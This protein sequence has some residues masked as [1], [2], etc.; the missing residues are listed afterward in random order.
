MKYDSKQTAAAA[1]AKNNL[2]LLST[3]I[4]VMLIM[5]FFAKMMHDMVFYAGEMTQYVQS[6]SRDMHDMRNEFKTMTDEVARIDKRVENMNNKMNNMDVQVGEIQAAISKD[7]K[8]LN[9]LVD[10][11]A[12]DVSSMTSN[13]DQIQYIMLGMHRALNYGTRT[14]THPVRMFKNFTP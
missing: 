10:Y 13:M 11:M 4:T 3:G 6:M 8:G 14:L 2:L 9:L 5:V 7:I 1:P 12:T